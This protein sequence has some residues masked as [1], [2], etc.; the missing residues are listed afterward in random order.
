MERNIL[1]ESSERFKDLLIALSQREDGNMKAYH[2]KG[3]DK[4]ALINRKRF[5]NKLGISES[6]VVSVRSVH[7]S[8]IES[9][10]EEDRGSFID[11]TDG[12]ITDQTDVFLSITVADCLPVMIFDPLKKVLGLLHCGWK[13]L[14]KGI[15]EKAVNR[16]REDFNVDPENIAAGIGPGIGSCHYEV[17]KD[18]LITFKSYPQIIKKRHDLFFIDLKLLTE[19]K[20][21][22]CGIKS[23]GIEINPVCTYCHS[24]KYFSHRKDRSRPVDAMMFLAGIR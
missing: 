8:D 11:N 1:F 7:G 22:E 20:L 3:M 15:I 21:E 19:L 16:M 24:D 18:F 6:K 17:K 4:R 14:E 12:L 5:L 23:E 10:T 13:G 2:E 9:V